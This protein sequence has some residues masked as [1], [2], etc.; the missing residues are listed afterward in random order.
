MKDKNASFKLPKYERSRSEQRKHQGSS[1][2]FD[3]TSPKRTGFFIKLF[4]LLF[5]L[6]CLLSFSLLTWLRGDP[7]AAW[8]RAIVSLSSESTKGVSAAVLRSPLENHVD[9]TEAYAG[10]DPYFDDLNNIAT[11]EAFPGEQDKGLAITRSPKGGGPKIIHINPAQKKTGPLPKAPLP[12]L[13]TKGSYGPLPQIA[14]DGRKPWQAY[15]RPF[16]K[17]GHPLV[18]IIV[19]GLGLDPETTRQAIRNLPPDITLGFAPHADNLQDWIDEARRYGHETVVQ[20]PMEAYGTKGGNSD[21]NTLLSSSKGPENMKRLDWLMGRTTGYFAVMNYL[22]GKFLGNPRSM[23]PVF[24]KLAQQGIAFVHDGAGQKKTVKSLAHNAG[25]PYLPTNNIIDVRRD[26]A[27]IDAQLLNLTLQARRHKQALG[28]GFAF[29]ETLDRL[30]AWSDKLEKRGIRLAPAS[31][32]FQE[33][34]RE[35]PPFSEDQ[36]IAEIKKDKPITKIAGATSKTKNNDLIFRDPTPQKKTSSPLPKESK[37]K[38]DGTR[39]R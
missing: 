36:K 12:G 25:L 37:K 32:L 27:D 4:A 28:F 14:P 34:T 18:A 29:P 31:A 10:Y 3:L 26:R 17:T 1:P 22:G 7:G 15:A 5:F 16:Q 23:E 33:E 11:D 21:S 35:A 9:S 8:P 13:Y 6:I 19:G 2:V 39:W 38:P 24:T 30:K 20:L